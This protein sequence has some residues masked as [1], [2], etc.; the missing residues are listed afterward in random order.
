MEEP[1]ITLSIAL[2]IIN[3]VAL[4]VGYKFDKLKITVICLLLFDVAS[5]ITLAKLI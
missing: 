1:E 3:V 2:T 5:I 4:A